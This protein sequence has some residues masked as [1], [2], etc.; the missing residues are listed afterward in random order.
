M[1]KYNDYPIHECAARAE[2]IIQSDPSA[3]VFQKWT[4]SNCGNRL[5]M[6]DPNVFYLSGRCD[7]CG[8]VTEIKKCNYMLIRSTNSEMLDKLIKNLYT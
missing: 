6:P 2:K 1:T 5:G 7:N 3:R 4:C 8:H